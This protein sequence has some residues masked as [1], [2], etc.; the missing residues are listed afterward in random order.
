MHFAQ[1]TLSLMRSMSALVFI[2]SKMLTRLLSVSYKLGEHLCKDQMRIMKM[3]LVT[4][5]S[6]NLAHSTQT[7]KILLK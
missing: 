7:K 5:L 6:L 1:L 2:N 4:Y 3:S